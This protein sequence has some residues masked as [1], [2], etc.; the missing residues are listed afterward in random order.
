ME[1][2]KSHDVIF[3]K[4]D[5]LGFFL[6]NYFNKI[7]VSFYL[8]TGVSDFPIDERFR[9]F[10]NRGKI[11]KWFGH[12]ITISHPKCIK[13][14]IGFDENERCRGGPADGEGGDQQLLEELYN[15]RKNFRDKKDKLLVTHIGNTHSS[16][17]N[18]TKYFEDKNFADFIGKKIF[19]EYMKKINEYKFVLCPRGNGEDTHRFWEVSLMG[20]IPVVERNGLAD[21][22]G[23]FPCIIVNKFSDVNEKR[24][25]EFIYDEEKAKNIK[26]YLFIKEFEKFF[27][28]I[29]NQ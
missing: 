13:L 6:N 23:K 9:V 3:V 7:S 2:I 22:F 17:K 27:K 29:M 26:T 28:K 20:S 24:L 19:E 12:N 18:V 14:P 15:Q 4:T 8:V 21:F 25:S 11:I 10:L 16:R 1:N 5:L